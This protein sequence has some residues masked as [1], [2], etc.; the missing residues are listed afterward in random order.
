MATRAP[1]YHAYLRRTSLTALNGGTAFVSNSFSYDSASRRQTVTDNGSG[2]SAHYSHLAGSPLLGQITFT[3]SG[4]TIMTTTNRYDFLNRLVSISS[5]PSASSPVSFNYQYNPAN[6]RTALTNADG[7]FWAYGYDAL[8][9]VTNGVKR[10]GD[11]TLVAGDQF[12]YAFDTIGN[13]T[14]TA[15]GGD[16]NGNNLRST[17]YSANNLNQYTNRTVPGYAEITGSAASNAN[18]TIWKAGGVYLAPYRKTNYFWGELTAANTSTAA[19]LQVTNVGVVTNATNQ[20][21]ASLSSG[22]LFVPQTPEQ[23]RYD[24]DGN[25]TNDG[26]WAYV[27]DGE[28]RLIKM[29]ANTS[30]GPQLSLTFT[31]DWQGG[32]IQKQVSANGVLTNNATFLYDRWNIIARL[33]A[34]NNGAV[35]NYLWGLDVSGS[36]QGARG[37]GGLLEVN[38]AANGVQLAAY[39]GNGNVAALVAAGGTVSA[40]YEYG[41]FG[42][43]IRATLPMTRSNP[44]RFSS[45]YQDDETDF[46]YYGYRYATTS[47]GSWLSRDPLAEDSFSNFFGPQSLPSAMPGGL[48]ASGVA[49][50]SP[51]VGLS[52]RNAA[53]YYYFV[54]R[55]YDPLYQSRGT[56][57]SAGQQVFTS[58]PHYN[59][60]RVTFPSSEYA[61]VANNPVGV[62]DALGLLAFAPS[63]AG[64]DTNA[65]A[66]ALQKACSKARKANCFK[67]CNLVDNYFAAMMESGSDPRG[68][69]VIVNCETANNPRCLSRPDNPAKCGFTD[70]QSPRQIHL[71]MNQTQGACSDFGCTLLHELAHAVGGV[72]IDVN[73]SRAHDLEKC[74][75]CP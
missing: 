3:N 34:A 5:V 72:G 21:T 8:G 58:M 22:G 75:G 42:E 55:A 63:C 57:G 73:D 67:T 40:Q 43:V 33:N 11:N 65:M 47:T 30:V 39:D 7:S 37:A 31:Y 14:S 54:S 53:Y 6:Q 61:F 52:F 32:R 24:G 64:Q 68:F 41:P 2:N 51:N 74:I 1:R 19:W 16:Q 70:E 27:W 20:A 12:Q 17:T 71:F 38:D 28:N 49:L 50:Q 46:L 59:A 18:V 45:K 48:V 29:T 44:L 36:L 13:R 23:F 25:L 35:Q 10:W 4:V 62:I 69:G 15:A 56:F 9:Q 26:R 66:R 60:T